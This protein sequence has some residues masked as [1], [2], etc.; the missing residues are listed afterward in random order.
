MIESNF[1]LFLQNHYCGYLRKYLS[2]TPDKE[3][4]G[5]SLGQKFCSYPGGLTQA[6]YINALQ[7]YSTAR[8][9]LDNVKG[10][11]SVVLCKKKNPIWGSV[12][13]FC[14]PLGWKCPFTTEPHIASVLLSTV[15]PQVGNAHLQQNPIQPLVPLSTVIPWVGNAHL[16]QNPIKPRF[17][18]AQSSLGLEM[19]IYNRTP[20]QIFILSR[21]FYQISPP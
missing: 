3:I 9:T 10:N 6:N 18:S 21:S 12:A 11:F 2:C 13:L 8:T 4:C 17:L 14:H 15:I 1:P 20:Y 7:F 19:P 5:F 16:Q